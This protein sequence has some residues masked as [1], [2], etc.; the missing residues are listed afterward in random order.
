[1]RKDIF[2]LFFVVLL[3]AMIFV[4]VPQTVHAQTDA[5]TDPAGAP[6]PCPDT[7][8][9][10]PGPKN[11]PP[12]VPPP[13]SQ[14]GSGLSAQPDCTP[15]PP[16]CSQSGSGLSAQ[17]DCTPA[18]PPCSQNGSGLSAQQECTQTPTPIATAL[19]ITG[20]GAGPINPSSLLPAVQNPDQG[21]SPFSLPGP[22]GM[23]I[24]LL[25]LGGLF[26]GLLLPAIQKRSFNDGSD[27]MGGEPHMDGGSDQFLKFED[28]SNQFQKADGS[29][30]GQDI[31]V[32]PGSKG[33][34]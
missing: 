6:M 22:L 17:P 23:L 18:P 14:S 15:A 27:K 5:C 21:S 12:Q 13:G 31:S 11:R 16:P 2:S 32:Q 8:G 10:K 1:M 7:G 28:P 4:L 9:S 34:D 19:P 25:I 33:M 3:I 24:A 20:G 26:F 30:N 29:I